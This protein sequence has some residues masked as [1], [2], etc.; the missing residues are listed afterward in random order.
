MALITLANPTVTI[1]NDT[2][3]PVA[4]SV[5]LMD[6]QGTKSVKGVSSGGG[7]TDIVISEN[8]EERYSQFKFSLHTVDVNMQRKR[9]WRAVDDSVGVTISVTQGDFHRV[10]RHAILTNDPEQ[11]FGSE[12]SFEVEFQ[13]LPA[14]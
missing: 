5:S 3:L 4:N 7:F 14:V 11:K 2:F 9:D 6:G 10:I 8:V 12:E 13:G 1:N